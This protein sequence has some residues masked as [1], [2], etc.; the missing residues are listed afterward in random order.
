[1]GE[2]ADQAV[3]LGFQRHQL[4]RLLDALRGSARAL[5]AADPGPQ[6]VSAGDLG[7]DADVLEHGEFGKDLGDLEGARHAAR[8]ALMRR[9]SRVMSRPSKTM[10]PEVGGKNP[11]IRLKKVVLPAPF[12]PMIA[13]S[14]PLATLSETSRT[15]T[16]L[17]KR[18]VTFSIS[19]NVHALPPLQE[20]QQA[21]RE[22]QHDQDEQQADERH[23]VDGDAR[24][25]ILQHDEHGGAE[26]RPPEAAHAAHHRHHDEIAGLA[27][28]QAARIGEIVDA[29]HRA[30]R[31]SP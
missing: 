10:V 15:A 20:A 28:V 19:S 11:L 5:R 31:Q 30:R 23:P 9:H 12:G 3:G 26:Q 6:A 2:L 24:E 14:S 22:E 1:M 7:G 16:R 17:P 4:E 25:I 8:D 21:A 27:V 29:A 13:R 18:L